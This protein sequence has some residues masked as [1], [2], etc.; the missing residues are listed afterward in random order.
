MARSRRVPR[1]KTRNAPQI[2]RGI[3][4]RRRE[5]RNAARP[6]EANAT[7]PEQRAGNL[8]PAIT[9][10]SE[11]SESSPGTLSSES[12]DSSSEPEPEPETH[13]Q[14]EPIDLPTLNNILQQREDHLLNRIF[15]HLAS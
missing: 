2:Q 7:T 3:R 4:R 13:Q 5:Q 12:P 11:V 1:Q 10:G 15:T 9:L 8:L 14:P 6:T